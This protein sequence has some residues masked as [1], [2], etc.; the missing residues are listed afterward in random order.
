MN[1]Q[2]ARPKRS[3]QVLLPPPFLEEE[4]A[5]KASRVRKTLKLSVYGCECGSLNEILGWEYN[6]DPTT[7]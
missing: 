1:R 7:S 2:L 5:M 3:P 6:C 4:N